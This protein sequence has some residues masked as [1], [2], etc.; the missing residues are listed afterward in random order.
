MGTSSNKPVQTSMTVKLTF[1]GRVLLAMDL[2][3]LILSAILRADPPFNM[4]KAL[5]ESVLT[6]EIT[7]NGEP[8]YFEVPK[9]PEFEDDN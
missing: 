4:N 5:T 2:W 3:Y 8:H 7:L 1:E 6:C 9:P